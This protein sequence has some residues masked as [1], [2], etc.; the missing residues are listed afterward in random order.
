MGYSI[1]WELKGAV[2]TYA[3]VVTFDDFVAALTSIHSHPDY[4]QLKYALHDFLA[5]TALDQ[6]Q[7]DLSI[8]VAHTLG[9][10][11]SNPRIRTAIV[12]VLPTL[13]EVAHQFSKRT[14]QKVQVFDSVEKALEWAHQ[15]DTSYQKQQ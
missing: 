6:G 9:A 14:N 1:S 15:P 7:T 8:L 10:S 13:V 2:C 3:G 11:Y 12:A 5:V 4:D